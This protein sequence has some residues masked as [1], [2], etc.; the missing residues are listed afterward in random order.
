MIHQLGASMVESIASTPAD[1]PDTLAVT[2]LAMP[3]PR[4]RH[5]WEF[6]LSTLMI[7]ILFV[8][9]L[10]AWK[11][12][13][14]KAIRRAVQTIE[15]N[16]GSVMFEDPFDRSG[17]WKSWIHPPMWLY[18]ALGEE[19]FSEVI[20]VYVK[21]DPRG[22]WSTETFPAIMSLSNIK[23]LEVQH[24]VLDDRAMEAIGT[25]T[26]L[27]AI[28][29]DEGTATVSRSRDPSLKFEPQIATKKLPV[30]TTKGLHQI[31]NLRGLREITL[32]TRAPID[33]PISKA[34]AKFPDLRILNIDHH[35]QDDADFQ[36]LG[37]FGQLHK[38]RIANLSKP[39]GQRSSSPLPIS[40]WK[41]LKSLLLHQIQLTPEEV[42]AVSRLPNLEELTLSD[43]DLSDEELLLLRDIP[44]LKH[45]RLRVGSVSPEAVN[46]FKAALPKVI[47]KSF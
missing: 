27:E 46:A 8:A 13:H 5:R 31:T 26:T 44:K 1:S 22:V 38:L 25:I 6:R 28:Q 19:Y 33:A 4:R 21:S 34:I 47:I 16:S 29:L 15:M 43:S 40:S 11:V 30:L 32:R 12:N 3:K 17:R 18:L 41:S 39:S 42:L 23:R 37:D 2:T 7:V 45:L 10:V 24:I 14:A 20:A 35:D 9:V 36:A